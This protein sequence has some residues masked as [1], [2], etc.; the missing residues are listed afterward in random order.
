[1]GL[2]SVDTSNPDLLKPF[3]FKLLPNGK[4]SFEVANDLKVED[5][6]SSANKVIKV[7]LR[8]N[9]EGEF[10]GTAVFDIFIIMVDPQG[11]KGLKAKK[12]QE[13]KMAQFALACGVTTKDELEETGEVPLELCKGCFV[14]AVIGTKANSYKDPN[15]DELITRDK[16][17]IV[18]YLFDAGDEKTE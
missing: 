8:C 17:T 16:N 4:H 12:I 3:E 2:V 9:E 14:E 7:E 6:K 5:S 18:K 13:G 10:K 11:E 1:M 15:T